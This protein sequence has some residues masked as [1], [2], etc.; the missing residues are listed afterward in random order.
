MLR[1]HVVPAQGAPFDH[2]VQGDSLVIGR[3]STSDLPLADRFLS[4]HHARLF[5]DG[6]RYLIEDLGSRNGT[7]LNG[8]PVVQ[9]TPVVAGDVIRISGSVLSLQPLDGDVRGP[10]ELS[11]DSSHTVFRPAAELLAQDA[12]RPSEA[13]D[14]H[15]L[16]RYADRLRLVNEVHQ[17]LGEALALPELL[18]L[19]LDRLFD[20]LRPQHGALYLIG[21]TGELQLAASRSASGGPA[22][23]LR[24][25]SLVEEVTEKCVGAL[26]L[27]AQT[28][29]RFA[30]A[31]SML[32]AGVRSLVAAPLLAEPGKALGMVLLHS[33]AA[34][35]Q[36]SEE[37]L[38]LLVS[39][40]SVAAI[41]IRNVAL[42]EEAAQRRVLEEE[43]ALA[44]RIQEGLLPATL[45]Q[46]PGWAL[47]AHNTASRHVSGDLYQ[48]IPRRDGAECGLM[49]ADVA[50]K[51][52]AAS[53]L[54]ASVEALAAGAVEEGLR[55][56]DACAR[57]SRLLYQRTP[58]EKYAT[59][60]LAVADAS[61]RVE[62]ANAG[63]N[64]GLLVRA[65]GEVERLGPTGV[66]LGILPVVAYRGA[67]VELLP[68]DS[69]VLYTDGITE[70]TDSREEELGLERLVAVCREHRGAT[71]EGLVAAIEAAV[72]RFAEGT[73]A[74]DDRT[75]MVLRRADDAGS[76]PRS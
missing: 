54:A 10:G 76:A 27:D 45:P 39:L 42:A 3:S 35:K 5:R 30:A 60:I 9:P 29:A 25:Q 46:L 65:G 57:I 49:V 34:V 58:H 2:L 55:P 56:A 53:L 62:Y 64:P 21:P 68:G 66:P 75:V 37:D 4:R 48:A 61:G 1:L 24:S 12:H 59:A 6:D 63:H 52:V 15:T 69:L 73:P 17:A 7:L 22:M 32:A 14:R 13:T 28:D 72:A 50:G 43:L 38:E 71:P 70:A 33:N 41:R 51:G 20:H 23:Q 19:I 36:F 74:G 11:L 8:E 26:V 47:H 44:R 67:T 31:Q 18:R 16:M 40:A